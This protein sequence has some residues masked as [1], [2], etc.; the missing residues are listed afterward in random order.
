MRQKKHPNRHLRLTDQIQRDIAQ[1]LREEFEISRDGLVTVS[2]VDLSAD[3]HHVKIYFSVL[4]GDGERLQQRLNQRS[5]HFQ[6]LLFKRLGLHA[7]PQ[8]HFLHDT[9]TES[10]IALT[11]LIDAA[12]RVTGRAD[13]TDEQAHE[14]QPAGPVSS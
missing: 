2:T 14:I 3:N 4:N 7:A 13:S 12:N 1:A 6:A 9:Q 11:Q 5:A 8:V 10:G